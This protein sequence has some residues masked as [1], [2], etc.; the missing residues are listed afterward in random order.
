MGVTAYA[1][2]DAINW[3]TLKHMAVSAKMLR[4]RVDH[5]REDTKALA[6]GRA[7][8]CAV[9]ERKRWQSEVIA[10]P[11]DW[12]L[13]S[14]KGKAQRAQWLAEASGNEVV[15][16]PYFDR[17][18]RAGKDA[19]AEFEQM[20]AETNARVVVGDEPAAV[21]FAPEVIVLTRTDYE[22]AERCATAVRAH[23][24]AAEWLRG[25]RAEEVVTWTDE[26]TGIACKARLDF[27]TPGSAIDL[28][29]GRR[30]TLRDIQADVARYG[31]HGQLAW[32]LDG[33]KRAKRLP[34]LGAKARLIYVQT[35][36]PF[37]VVPFEVDSMALSA[38]RGF[39]RDL[40][41]KYAR[42]AESEWWPGL[43]TGPV[44]LELPRWA[45]DGTE[46]ERE[47]GF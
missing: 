37:D 45:P 44:P 5:P 9:L 23:P 42:C 34:Q 15:A 47:D 10:E 43:A 4:H 17:R 22:I 40:L 2:I 41:R 20:V 32:Y 6:L 3:S 28:K 16:R 19:A 14:N 1:D 36:A 29:S 7:I 27:I 31:Y 8:H 21:V 39:Y 33:A 18:S 38:G 11:D 26:E 35:E 46:D 12:D 30:Q 13:R 24:T 25:G